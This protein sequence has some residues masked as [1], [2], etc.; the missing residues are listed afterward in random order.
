MITY[1]WKTDIPFLLE[2]EELFPGDKLDE[3]RY[4]LM[5]RKPWIRIFIATSGTAKVGSMVVYISDKKK[6]ARIYSLAIKPSFRKM[7]FGAALVRKAENLAREK[8]CK[9]IVLEVR[10]SNIKAINLYT[11]LGYT[12]F[13]YRKN[14]Y[15]D[16]E[17]AYRMEKV[18]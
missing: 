14:Y 18:L 9:K 17:D 16:G 11:K 10:I 3:D 1:A 4:K 6:T 12:I 15:E 2:M 7:G 8:S 5:F 13:G